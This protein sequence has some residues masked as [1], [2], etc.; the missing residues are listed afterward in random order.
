MNKVEAKGG[1][2]MTQF[3]RALSEINVDLICANSP[4]AKGRIER[5]F[6][7]LQDR[8]V[9]ELRLVGISTP[10]T[11]NAFLPGF[12]DTHN[13]RFAKVPASETDAH[14][15]VPPNVTLT[16]VFAWKKERTV[17]NLTIQ[18]DQA[19]FLLEPSPATRALARQRVTVIDYPDGRIA[20]RHAGVD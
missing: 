1:D 15:P 10:D 2:G 13:A 3:T 11:A 14:R 4:Q 18:Y 6:G 7:T 19:M 20:V 8:L 9:K 12:L 5:S 16:D 17:T